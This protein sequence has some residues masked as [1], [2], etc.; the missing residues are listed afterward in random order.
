MLAKLTKLPLKHRCQW[1]YYHFIRGVHFMQVRI[2]A[3]SLVGFMIGRSKFPIIL[4]HAAVDPPTPTRF[5]QIEVSGNGGS[6]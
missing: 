5:C 6:G 4:V 3:A 1:M 2:E